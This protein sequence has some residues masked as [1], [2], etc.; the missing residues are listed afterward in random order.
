[1]PAIVPNEGDIGES[2]AEMRSAIDCVYLSCFA[3]DARFLASIL[4]LARVRLH[5]AET[6]EE[7]DF[8]IT[9]T[10]ATVVLSDM[11]FLDGSWQHAA[12]MVRRLHSL[13]TVLVVAD[14]VDRVELA[15]GASH[16]VF[17]ICWKPYEVVDL[18]RA[19]QAA[20]D[21]TMDRRAEYYVSRHRSAQCVVIDR[22]K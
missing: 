11:M 2:N 13:L 21:A 5:R 14:P 12:A 6:L 4:G 20:H 17:N 1:M 10:A 16:G 7:A 9:A 19:I 3:G 18:R 15:N 8:L 22:V